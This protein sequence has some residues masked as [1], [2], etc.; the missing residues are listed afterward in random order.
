MTDSPPRFPYASPEAHT[1]AGEALEAGRLS[2]HVHPSQRSA[3]PKFPAIDELLFYVGQ[4]R[5]RLSCEIEAAHAMLP[6]AIVS[7]RKDRPDERSIAE[8]LKLFL[9]L[10]DR[11]TIEITDERDL[12][13]ARC[14]A[15]IDLLKRM[16]TVAFNNGRELPLQEQVDDALAEVPQ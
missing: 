4:S 13:A 10:I 15:L 1:R 9:E 3:P 16:K 12:E 5:E 14:R 6:E 7:R 11:R 8:R 2:V